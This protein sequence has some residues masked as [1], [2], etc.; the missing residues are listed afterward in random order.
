MDRRQ[1]LTSAG[2]TGAAASVAMASDASQPAADEPR[3]IRPLKLSKGDPVA[4][5]A[6][7]TPILEP[8]DLALIAPTLAALGLEARPSPHVHRRSRDFSTSIEERV[9]DLHEAFRS[10]ELRGIFCARG[11]YGAAELLPHLDYELIRANPKPLIG[12]SDIT[13]LHQA[14]GRMA[15][16]ATFSGPMPVPS[17]MTAYTQAWFRRAVMDSSPLGALD[18]PPEPKPLRPVYPMRTIVPGAASGPIVGGNLTLTLSLLG[19]PYEL[20]T[21]G[22]ILFVEDVDEEPY[23]VGRM[24]RQLK[25]AGK[26]DAAAG[27]I[28]GACLNCKPSDYKPSTVSPYT[29]GEHIDQALEGLK[30][31]AI[32]GLAVG[33]TDDQLTIPLGA[34]A[35]LDADMNSQRVAITEAGVI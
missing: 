26:L 31:P 10:S 19:T 1:F 20:D 9:D 32:Y 3:W 28:V 2:L 8:A 5:I 18:N 15:G 23:R 24:L 27:V 29:L 33:H 30:G 6:P 13:V 17:A 22:K 34:M 12:Y 11:G 21:R 7:A 4:V 16:L 35:R 25:L 14:I